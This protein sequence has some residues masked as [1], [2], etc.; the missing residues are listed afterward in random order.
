M[1]TSSGISIKNARNQ[2]QLIFEDHRQKWGDIL[3]VNPPISIYGDLAESFKWIKPEELSQKLLEITSLDQEYLFDLLCTVDYKN[4]F[5]LSDCINLMI[6][7]YWNNKLT[8]DEVIKLLE[9][10]KIN[11][12]C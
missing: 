9:Y 4:S 8:K 7:G 3:G 6:T 5:E 12:S 10:I 11:Y 2:C 1:P